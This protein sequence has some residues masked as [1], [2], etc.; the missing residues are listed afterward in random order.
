MTDI[1]FFAWGDTH[2][3]Y[4]MKFGDAEINLCST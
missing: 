4:E 2:F 3:G 1:T